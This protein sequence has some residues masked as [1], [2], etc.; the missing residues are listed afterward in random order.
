MRQVYLFIPILLALTLISCNKVKEER[1]IKGNLIFVIGN[2]E[3]SNKAGSN[4]AKKMTQS[5]KG[6]RLKLVTNP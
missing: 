6:I 1:S 4:P 2:V 3:I 5:V